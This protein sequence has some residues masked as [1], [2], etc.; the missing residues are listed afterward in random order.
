MQKLHE[1]HTQLCARAHELG[2]ELPED[3]T[4]E[5]ESEETGRAVCS[6]I[7]ALI[8]AAP[9]NSGV[10]EGGEVVHNPD[11]S[12]TP[13]AKKPKANK[14]TVQSDG[15]A[16][17]EDSTMRKSTKTKKTV[18]KKTAK[19]SA[20]AN[21]RKPAG[22]KV[23]AKPR[24]DS[25]TQKVGVLLKRAGGC[26]RADILKATGWPAVSVQQMAKTCGLKLRKEKEPGKPIVYY[27]S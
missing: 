15:G 24:G 9:N 6:N 12:K 19:K 17:D 25:K 14:P 4:A 20:K 3:L 23:A 16:T 21:A 18:A 13:R 22:K 11:A 2:I 1:K 26:T 27:G 7:E 8:R 5:F 10:A